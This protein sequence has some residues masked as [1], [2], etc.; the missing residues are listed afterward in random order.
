MS[1]VYSQYAY[2]NDEEFLKEVDELR[3]KTEYARITLLSWDRED[4]LE[5]I[6]GYIQSGSV[7]ID[8][9]SAIRRTASLSVFIPESETN[10][11]TTSYKFSLNKKVRLEIGLK[12]VLDR[13]ADYDILWFPLGVYVITEISINHTNAGVTLSL[14]LRDKMVLL[15]GECGGT[16][17]AS[18]TFN[19]KEFMNEEGE[20]EISHPTIYQIIQEAVNHF[21]GEQL[22]RI[23]ISDLD[24]R[25]KQV[26]RWGAYDSPIYI[27]L[28][29]PAANSY[30]GQNTVE[31]EFNPER[32]RDSSFVEY[33]YGED[34]G[35][36]YTPFTYPGELIGDAGNSV[37]DILTKIKDLLGNFEFFYDIDGNFRFQEIKNYLNT[38][39][40]S[41]VLTQLNRDRTSDTVYN[42]DNNREDSASYIVDM[43]KG[44]SVYDFTNSDL[45]ISYSNNPDYGN[46]KNDF[47]VW[48]IRKSITGQELPIRYHLAIDKKPAL[49]THNV[50]LYI[51]EEDGNL[52]ARKSENTQAVTTTD[53]RTE[54]YLQGIESEELGY[55]YNDY[56]MELM[57][58]WPKLYALQGGE[59]YGRKGN[60]PGFK[61][62]T[63]HNSL[64]MDFFLDFIDTS[65]ALG[66]YS[67][68]NIGRRTKVLVD[69]SIN[70]IFEPK[71]NDIV[72]IVND[73][74]DLE[75][76]TYE[77]QKAE[78]TSKKQNYCAIPSSAY[79]KLVLGGCYNGADVAIKD[80]L[81]QY[82]NYNESI[83]LSCLPIYHLDVNERI[84][85]AD[86]EAGISDDF[87]IK[88]ISCPL[89]QS[90]TMT[91]NANRALTKI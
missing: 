74:V 53:W 52:K 82:T 55:S 11:K 86:P 39:Q 1:S 40:A 31:V 27:N 66:E 6:Q 47:L 17:P 10:Y 51:D 50:E 91:I 36:I 33:N 89:G 68:S 9:S 85:V 78:C 72:F 71:V 65:S 88:N 24:T 81:Y 49:Q 42:D 18:V 61:D 73:G 7:N 83:S 5:E 90:G 34:I 56:Y 63:V 12:N 75:G 15:N 19:E 13:Y 16:L 45:V 70:C 41:T 43:G 58:E 67:V 30:A 44:K 25:I 23:L 46:I 59:E 21:G 4:D 80:L 28:I 69:N 29:D 22:G 38:T 37:V 20:W 8:S 87:I 48:G 26:V 62:R 57:N 76:R 79:Q 32:A 14:T 3:I 35:Y 2:L 60:T 77:E 54:L 84:T 64:D